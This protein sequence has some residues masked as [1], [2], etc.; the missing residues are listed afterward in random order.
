MEATTTT[1][2]LRRLK[3]ITSKIGSGATPR[4]GKN[5]YRSEGISLIR[6]L[7]VYD[8]SFTEE[9][10]AFIGEEQAA[11]LDNVVVQKDDTLLNITGASVARCCLTNPK[12]LPAR[13]NQH[14]A[15]VRVRPDVA[16]A[17]FVLYC[18]N[19]LHF[20]SRLLAVA[21]GGATREALTKT[22]I[23]DFEVCQPPLP[24]QRR[25]A[26]ILSAYD[27]LMENCQR[28]IRLLEA[29]ARALYR[30][31]FVHFRFPGH[32]GNSSPSGRGKGEGAQRSD[33]PQGWAATTLGEF[34]SNGSISLQTGPFG[35]Q[36]KASQYTDEGTPVINVRNIGFGVLK[37]DKLEFL[38]PERVEEHKRHKL[39]EGDIV[40]G[41][42]G[43]V[44]RHLLVTASEHGWIQGSDCIRL[45]VVSG[46]LTPRYLSVRFREDDHQRWMMNQCSG[47]PRWHL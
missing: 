32:E 6:S 34:V 13:V 40:F 5:A 24:V 37:S 27:E 45:R 14:V 20:K 22:T 2:P 19:S 25:I 3:D 42:K 41:R 43:A 30:E 11:E 33:I 47:E 36:L 23:E 46:P 29:M 17:R 31:W 26:G 28:R 44:E 16:D 18:I 1:W 21:Q 4:G 10:L 12:F 8:F 15:I 7:N 38:P 39:R 9:D 35:T